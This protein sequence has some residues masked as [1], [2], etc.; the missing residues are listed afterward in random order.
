MQVF[1]YGSGNSTLWYARHVAHVTACEHDH[2]WA[3]MVRQ[4]LS[5]NTL[6][7]ENDLGDAYVDE[8]AKHD[9]KFDVIVIDGRMRNLCAERCMPFLTANGVIIWDNSDRPEYQAGLKM[10]MELGF[11]CVDFT[12]MGPINVYGWTTSIFYRDNNV[13]EM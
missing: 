1:E 2:D 5:Q 4:K 3:T 13:F 12:G 6:L 8:I 10:L 11:R 7:I 9:R